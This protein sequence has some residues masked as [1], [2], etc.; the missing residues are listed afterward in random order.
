MV[1][2]WNTSTGE[3]VVEIAG[4]SLANVP[5]LTSESTSID[6]G[7]VVSVFMAGDQ[8]LILGKVTIPGDPG[9]VPSWS[10]DI[11]ALDATVTTVTTETIPAVQAVADAAQADATQAQA[12]AAQAASDA[13][14]AQAAAEALQTDLDAAESAVA[15]AQGE[16]DTLTG[17]TL[18]ALQSDVDAAALAVVAAQA[19]ADSAQ[20]DATSVQ[21][22]ISTLTGTTI[23]ALT[24]ELSDVASEVAGILPVGS[25]DISDDAITTAK[26]AANA[27]TAAELNAGAVTTAKLAAG[28]VTTNELGAGAVTAVKIAADT[29]TASELAA[30][31][32]VAGKIAAGTIVAADISTG[33][34]TTAKL[35]AGAVTTAKL[36]AGAVTATEIA[37]GAITAAK[38]S[39]T[40]IDGKTITGATIKTA[41]SG[42]RWELSSSPGNALYAYSG[43]ASEASPGALTVRTVGSLEAHTSLEAPS[44]TSTSGGYIDLVA[45]NNLSPNPAQ[46]Q[47]FI[48]ATS[49]ALEDPDTGET[50]IVRAGVLYN[51]DWKAWVNVSSLLNS[52]VW[53]GGSAPTP[54]FRY[55]P[56][57]DVGIRGVVKSGTASTIFSLP[58]GCRPPK[59]F[60]VQV[61]ING[62][63]A[64]LIIQANGDVQVPVTAASQNFTEFSCRFS[65]L[66]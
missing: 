58:S 1:R 6:V 22:D 25:T 16:L 64:R 54:Q 18:P 62:S 15:A 50:L 61:P 24:S 48:G 65:T 7:D 10:A 60:S 44:L 33:A 35:D 40:A 28:A 14:A 56:D 49:I 13:A 47:V 23:P 57:G 11:S 36:A 37:A 31:A 53:Y 19:A 8:M 27:V 59:G 51:V 63:S 4:G 17:T 9:T 55:Y 12:D 30:N 21:A 26:I 20:A 3:N 43:L 46:S 29:I 32:V 52:W 45:T 5:S 42:T 41:G 34:I 2:S 66:A 38:L 39:A